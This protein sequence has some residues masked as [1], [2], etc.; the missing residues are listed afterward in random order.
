MR[1]M[2]LF[3]RVI[4]SS[5]EVERLDHNC[6]STFPNV[7]HGRARSATRI[8]DFI[9]EAQAGLLSRPA[10]PGSTP[11]ATTALHF[12]VRSRP[13]ERRACG[14][15]RRGETRKKSSEQHPPRTCDI[16]Q[17]ISM[18]AADML[19]SATEARAKGLCES[20][21]HG[22]QRSGG[23]KDVGDDEQDARY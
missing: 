19:R 12:E 3:P 8:R 20:L 22:N 17:G 23:A 18:H 6:L 14:S 13:K 10:P 5:A 15:P 11:I 9:G 1:P 16:G 21:P 4:I 7:P 2:D